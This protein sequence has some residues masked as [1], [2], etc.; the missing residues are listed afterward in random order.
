MDKSI[1]R[2]VCIASLL[3][4]TFQVAYADDESE[5]TELRKIKAAY[6]EAVNTSHPEKI[7]P[8][9][10][11]N[12]TGVMVTG[13]EVKSFD[14]LE[15]YWKKIQNLIGPGGTYHV[16]VNVDTTEFYD[17]IALSRGNTEDVVRLGNGKE[18]SFSSHWTSVC[19][20]ENGAWKVLRI[21]AAM[22]PVNNTFV[23]TQLRTTRLLFGAG[24]LISGFLIALVFRQTRGHR[25]PAGS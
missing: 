23:T 18:F 2:W 11:T 1:T 13:E 21:H 8:Y 4:A 25:R 20:K 24:G 5:R 9:L 16:Q 12:V 17:G 10:A 3:V 14:G 6:E 22:D 15:A 19:H 7:A